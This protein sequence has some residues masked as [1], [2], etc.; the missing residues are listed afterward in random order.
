MEINRLS[1]VRQ[2]ANNLYKKYDLSVPV[3]LD[4]IIRKKHIQISEEEN[5]LGIDGV[6]RLQKDP[7]EIILN[8]ETTYE[9]RRRFTIAH[10]LGHICIP[11]HT[12]VDLCSLD[13]P[14][15]KIK[16][17]QMVNTQELE[18]NI[19]ASE[20]LM[21]TDWLK[22]TFELNT[23]DLS[24]LIRQI[25]DQAN[26]SFMACF[27]A[28]ENVLPAGNLFFV[29]TDAAELWKSFRGVDTDCFHVPVVDTLSFYDRVCYWKKGFRLSVYNVIHYR[30]LPTPD[31]SALNDIYL[32]CNSNIEEL[33]F[34]I[35]GGNPIL[36][37]PY[38]DK[39]IASLSDKFYV[40]IKIGD[41]CFR[42]FR[43]S[44]TAIRMHG[45]YSDVDS[46]YSYIQDNFYCYGRLDFSPD[47]CMLW[48]KECWRGDNFLITQVNPNDLL[49]R[50]VAELYLPEN[51]DH[52]LH[53]INGVIASINSMNKNAPTGQLYHLA[54]VRFETDPKYKEFAEHCC[55]EQYISGKISSLIAKRGAW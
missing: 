30:V 18:A 3:D 43:H 47:S 10:E 2:R 13:N 34:A 40:I 32:A 39:I 7:P 12:G 37:M 44:E 50:I 16:G 4:V 52:M 54:K 38:I 31:L 9:P 1:L 45:D 27:Y 53:S 28:L 26:T 5:Q 25:C 23:K 48:V 8:T 33:L 49:K 36:A 29:K 19:F 20:L 21:P 46:L 22:Q 14:Y 24:N 42:H 17:Q 6:C 11:W 51:S 55:F 35:S 41:V 15:V